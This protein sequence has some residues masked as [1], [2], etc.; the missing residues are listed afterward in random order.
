MSEEERGE[1]AT[2]LRFR[3]ELAVWVELRSDVGTQ[4]AWLRNLSPRGALLQVAEGPGLGS[5]VEVTFP[6]VERSPTASQPMA[7][8]GYVQHT[9]GWA[10]NTGPY[11]V[12]AV[13]WGSP[14]V[15]VERSIQ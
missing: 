7:L 6:G 9:M 5:W 15:V 10:V 2:W 4:F 11:R 12:I 13:R 14:R 3:P 1:R 8:E